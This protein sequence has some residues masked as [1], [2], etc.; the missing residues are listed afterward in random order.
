LLD[1]RGQ[2]VEARD[3][4]CQPETSDVVELQSLSNV[5]CVKSGHNCRVVA[6]ARQQ[7]HH[8]HKE[9]CSNQAQSDSLDDRGDHQ[10]DFSSHLADL[11]LP[12]DSPDNE[13]QEADHCE[14]VEDVPLDIQPVVHKRKHEVIA[15]SYGDCA[16]GRSDCGIIAP[17]QLRIGDG[18]LLSFVHQHDYVEFEAV[19]ARLVGGSPLVDDWHEVLVELGDQV[20]EEV[21]AVGS[22]LLYLG[23]VEFG[24]IKVKGD[25]CILQKILVI[26]LN[27]NSEATLLTSSS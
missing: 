12:G 1:G 22:Q 23:V 4:Q 18:C 8:D 20:G 27:Q 17:D 13:Q 16:V 19:Y 25:A 21:V 26:W 24:G 6:V 3:E 2:D 9:T 5:I 7:L 11:E 10:L 14:A 15:Y